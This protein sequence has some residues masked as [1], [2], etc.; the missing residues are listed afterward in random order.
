MAD[1]LALRGEKVDGA[2]FAPQALAQ[3]AV[4]V[5]SEA[6]LALPEG[7]A[8]ATFDGDARL[9]MADL[10]RRLHGAPD[11]RLAVLAGRGVSASSTRTRASLRAI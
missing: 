1:G 7:V 3:G 4:A 6:P 9:R 2:T 11:E 10:A 8:S 5:I